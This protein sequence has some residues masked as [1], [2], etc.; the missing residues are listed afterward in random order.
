MKKLIPLLFITTLI[1]C[2]QTQL[3]TSEPKASTITVGLLHIAPKWATTTADLTAN[4]ER[5]KQG[6]QL[7][8]QHGVHWVVTPELTL[9]GYRF[10]YTLGTDWIKPGTDSYT[11]S[12]QQTADQLDLVLF[13]S[14]LEKDPTTELSYNT[15][16]VIDRQGEVL[17]RHRKINTIPGSEAWSSKGKT[18]TLV[19]VDETQVGLL[20]CADAWPT[21]H[22]QRLTEQGAELLISSANWAPGLYG[23]GTTWED[24]AQQSGV[25]IIVNNRHGIEESLDM[26]QAKSVVSVPAK[27]AFPTESTT[28]K[29]IL[30]HSSTSDQLVVFELDLATQTL[31]N[32][33]RYPL[34]GN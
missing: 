28:G 27:P 34:A 26:R 14:H 15:L 1:G 25:P 33:Q 11:Q 10:R 3:K 4:T 8:K 21:T 17:A 29:R 31:A 18:P 2:S 23:P 30:E 19:E 24:R 6:M 5:V 9:T 7:A 20:I 16:F 22:T 32:I 12:L 13:L